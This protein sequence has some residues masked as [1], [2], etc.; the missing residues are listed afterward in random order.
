MWRFSPR[1][2]RGVWGEVQ[3]KK[4]GLCGLARRSVQGRPVPSEREKNGVRLES[5]RSQW[6]GGAVLTVLGQLNYTRRLSCTSRGQK[7]ETKVS[8]GSASS[9]SSLRGP[10]VPSPTSCRH[11]VFPR[12][13][14]CFNLSL[15]GLQSYQ[16]RAHTCSL[17]FLCKDP[18]SKC[19]RVLRSPRVR[20][21]ISEFCC[22]GRGRAERGTHSSAQSSF[23][24]EMQFEL[25]SNQ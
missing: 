6:A 16:V 23:P 1:T 4:M 25:P 5:S 14:L 10:Q 18:V 12:V 15:R 21:S 20:T 11:V 13:C 24:E 22:G 9:E 3:C 19:S 17:S 2:S 8:A 7:S